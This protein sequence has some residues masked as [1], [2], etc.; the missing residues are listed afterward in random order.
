MTAEKFTYFSSSGAYNQAPFFRFPIQE[1]WSTSEKIRVNYTPF[2]VTLKGRNLMKTGLANEFRFGFQGQETDDEMKGEGNSVNF[3]Y[4]MHD[5]R[6]G[7]FFAIDPLASKY[8]YNST[9]AFSEN[10]V[11]DGVELEG[12]E[13]EKANMEDTEES[14]RQLI[15]NPLLINQGNS[16]TCVIACIA[17][18]WL[19]NEDDKRILQVM[20]SLI[21][22]GSAQ[23]KQFKLEPS[24]YLQAQNPNGGQSFIYGEE[25]ERELDADWLLISSI[26]NSLNKQLKNGQKFL[27]MSDNYPEYSQTDNGRAEVKYLM[28]NLLGFSKVYEKYYDGSEA[29]RNS[30]DHI[31]V[32]KNLDANIKNGS[33]VTIGVKAP[34]LPGYG[35][36]ATGGHRMAYLGDFKDLGDGKISFR[37]QSWGK[38]DGMVITTTV[39]EFKKNYNGATWGKK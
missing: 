36:N 34:I 19:K 15:K 30:M 25:G 13:F 33:D 18:I 2:G 38:K 32:L 24:K 23:I 4:R 14:L 1:S 21:T 31:Q 16:G 22:D 5:S 28:K 27:G 11:I 35:E 9:Y 37:V 7:R 3:E 26:Q 10:R 39:E 8:S 12:K 6:L 17:Y 29:E 20:H